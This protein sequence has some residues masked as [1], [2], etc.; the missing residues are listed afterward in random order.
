MKINII[1][2]ADRL[3]IIIVNVGKLKIT[4]YDL[5]VVAY[6]DCNDRD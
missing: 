4:S 3:R 2:E 1:D 5:N 6:Q